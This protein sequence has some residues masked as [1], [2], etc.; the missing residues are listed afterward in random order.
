M[1][2]RRGPER[3]KTPMRG[4]RFWPLVLLGLAA[5]VGPGCASYRPH[6]SLASAEPPLELGRDDPAAVATKPTLPSGSVSFVDRHPLFSKPRDFYM[7]SGEN[8]LVKAGAA[9]VI[10]IPAG[11]LG[12]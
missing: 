10:G 8:K 6:R 2:G 12:E 9:T 7:N 5:L 3:N 4:R 11:V 1:S